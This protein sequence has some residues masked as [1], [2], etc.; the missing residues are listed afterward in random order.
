MPAASRTTLTMVEPP[1]PPPARRGRGPQHPDVAA[2]K[3]AASAVTLIERERL[4]AIAPEGSRK[5]GRRGRGAA[6]GSTSRLRARMA[7]RHGP[8]LGGTSLVEA[9]RMNRA[10]AA[11]ALALAGGTPAAVARLRA[12]VERDAHLARC[13]LQSAARPRA[14]APVLHLL[15][16]AALADVDAAARD[17][18]LLPN[19]PALP[20]AIA[21]ARDLGR[22]ARGA[23]GAP[24]FVA[25]AGRVSE[26]RKRPAL[27]ET[28][29]EA[30]ATL[31]VSLDSALQGG[32]DIAAAAPAAGAAGAAG[33]RPIGPRGH[34]ACGIPMLGGPARLW[35][36]PLRAAVEILVDGV[37]HGAGDR[38]A[39]R[40]IAPMLRARWEAEHPR[41]AAFF[42]IADAVARA[43]ARDVSAGGDDP[44]APR[45][46]GAE[47]RA[48]RGVARLRED[49]RA[50]PE[51]ARLLATVEEI[52][53]RT[54]QPHGWVTIDG[55]LRVAEKL[56]ER[57]GKGSGGSRRRRP[58]PCPAFRGDFP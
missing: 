28:E 24:G 19:S 48:M 29:R 40:A 42:A 9:N 15:A 35:S 8:L 49:V 46:R 14:A 58:G 4:A 44:D 27:T 25:L 52:S 20:E 12:A 22:W 3:A 38:D 1:A 5:L 39:A 34:A 23:P 47:L 54:T 56:L 6:L 36:L 26:L 10:W 33:R 31:A 51:L 21:L 53:V 32:T 18:G 16:A 2:L 11:A 37:L 13:M 7:G 17:P 45:P 43:I 57:L 30:A 41:L 55:P 50:D